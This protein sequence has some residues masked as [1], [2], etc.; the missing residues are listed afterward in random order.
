[1]EGISCLIGAGDGDERWRW[2]QQRYSMGDELINNLDVVDAKNRME[3]QC[4]MKTRDEKRYEKKEETKAGVSSSNADKDGAEAYLYWRAFPKG[5]HGLGHGWHATWDDVL[6]TQRRAAQIHVLSARRP[7]ANG[8][9]TKLPMQKK[10]RHVKA[11]KQLQFQR[12]GPPLFTA[13]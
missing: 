6:I 8:T 12:A 13:Q 5:A 4:W 7:P 2:R 9:G 11:A 10:K 1:M 3:S